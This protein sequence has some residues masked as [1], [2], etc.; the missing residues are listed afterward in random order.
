MGSSAS[1]DEESQAKGRRAVLDAVW[2][3]AREGHG[4]GRVEAYT[5]TT[6]VY[7]WDPSY[8]GATRFC[9]NLRGRV[10]DKGAK[11]EEIPTQT[12]RTPPQK[13]PSSTQ[14]GPSLVLL[15]RKQVKGERTSTSKTRKRI[16]GDLQPREGIIT[17]P[18]LLLEGLCPC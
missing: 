8:D 4:L 14:V 10:S 1:P 6:P 3:I 18:V 16:Q 17:H 15:E 7:E 11:G 13:Q 9:M 2:K 12:G 5:G